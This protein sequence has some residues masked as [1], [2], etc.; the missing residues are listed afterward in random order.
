MAV[1]LIFAVALYNSEGRLIRGQAQ[2]IGEEALFDDSSVLVVMDQT[3][4][5]VNKHFSK[6]FFGDVAIS[7]VEDLTEVSP[8]YVGN[9]DGE[10]FH[11]I[12]K[13]ELA[14]HDKSYVL[15]AVEKIN[16]IDG[17]KVASPNY[18]GELCATVNDTNYSQQWGLNGSSG[19]DI[20]GAWDITTG[21]RE[22]R[23]GVI[24]S[25]ISPHEDL[26][27]N[28]GTGWNFVEG[29]SVSTN[30]DDLVGHGTHVAGI[31]GAIGN[32]Q[33]G[34][35]G[36]CQEVTLVPLKIT[37]NLTW[38]VSAAVR[39]ITRAAE[40]WG[41]Q[42]Q[43]D[44]LNL[45][46]TAPSP[47][48]ALSFAIENYPGVVVCA[49]GNGALDLNGIRHGYDIDDDPLYPAC[50]ELENV[51]TV[52]ALTS[53][54]ARWEGSNYGIDSVDI[55]APGDHILSTFPTAICE[56]GNCTNED[57]SIHLRPGYHYNSGT[58]MATP[59]VAGVAA[60][61]LSIEPT[62]SAERIKEI[63]LDTAESITISTADGTQGVKKLNADGAVNYLDKPLSS[64]FGGGAGTASNP[65]QIRTAEQFA[66]MQFATTYVTVPY[67]G[68]EQRISYHFILKNDITLS[69]DWV[70]FAYKFT[71]DFDGNEKRI[72]YSM[73]LS[74]A[75]INGNIYQGLFGFVTSGASIY[76][77][78][79]KDCTITSNM[80]TDLTTTDAGASIGILAGSIFDGANI[81]DVIISN[82]HIEC[83]VS[84]ASVGALAG[85]VFSSTVTDCIV[86]KTDGGTS[87]IFVSSLNAIF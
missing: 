84:N 44:L 67:Q 12:L 35:S 78:E 2:E 1:V 72:T 64:Y 59:H 81:S 50:F 46:A 54:G 33:T 6:S 61:M 62:L 28:L 26:N 34:V 48:Y 18:I 71:G 15:Q 80:T 68:V 79:L 51:I 65:F 9:I 30:T 56:A 42:D 3:A 24:D 73:N 8:E 4:G 38:S 52:G 27:A 76:D 47:D 17:V 10:R 37:D 11:Q 25:G 19:I 57:G 39:A 60:L 45:S 20:E 49:A 23:I 36:V 43:I 13:L 29:S 70:P 83:A 55:Y 14:Y 22:V 74:Q 31:I 21:S 75:D 69:D 85:S 66:N 41:T 58:S 16:Q 40:L 53:A 86:R 32:N 5:E 63:I 87:S 82:P 77:L 7:S